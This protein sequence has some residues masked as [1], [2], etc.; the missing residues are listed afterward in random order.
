[1][2]INIYGVPPNVLVK[3]ILKAAFPG[4][5]DSWVD[6]ACGN[7]KFTSEIG[8]VPEMGIGVDV[9]ADVP[10]LPQNFIFEREKIFDWLLKDKDRKF[11]VA[12]SF[13]FIEHL[14]KSESLAIIENLKKIAGLVVL[15]TP[16]GFLEQNAET[17]HLLDGN[18]W[19]WH[20]CGFSPEEL[21]KLGFTVFV[22]KNV[23]YRPVGNDRSFD[24]LI[25]FWS[26]GL[27][28]E[29]IARKIRMNSIRYN[30]SPTH[31]YRTLRDNI[32]RP[33]F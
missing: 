8:V 12:S 17:D 21:E 6:V 28:A 9:S 11:S 4:K 27:D 5:V 13:E 14:E 15:S 33:L 18:P 19:L 26:E 1:M 23:H 32:L 25:A 16:S 31:L 29:R 24:K 30:F 20:R 10:I 22:L 2:K 7:G 3:W